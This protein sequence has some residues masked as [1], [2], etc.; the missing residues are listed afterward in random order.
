MLNQRIKAAQGIADALRPAEV[1][2]DIAISSVSR[3]IGVIVD[4]RRD[5]GVHFSLCQQSLAALGGAVNGLVD[6]RDRVVKAHAALAE[7]RI[8][9]GLRAVAIGDVGDCPPPSGSLAI[10]SEAERAAA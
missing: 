8:N 7:D 5:S 4:G 10:V 9:A 6:A 1:D 3:L 2:I